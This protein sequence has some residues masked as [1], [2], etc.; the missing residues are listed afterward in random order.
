MRVIARERGEE[1]AREFGVEYMEISSKTEG[2]A[3]G[4][5]TRLIERFDNE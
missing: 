4:L 5:I 1:L 2:S 3:E